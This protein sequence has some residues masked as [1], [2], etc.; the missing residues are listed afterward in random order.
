M[1]WNPLVLVARRVHMKSVC[2]I[3]S[4]LLLCGCVNR[5]YIGESAPLNGKM[6]YHLQCENWG[7]LG[8]GIC[9]QFFWHYSET[10]KFDLIVLPGKT[11][12]DLH[13]V[14]M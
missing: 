1:D 12:Y 5:T 8:V 7:F 9:S 2:A 4:G 3:M 10:D 11:D 14:E 6:T 13:E